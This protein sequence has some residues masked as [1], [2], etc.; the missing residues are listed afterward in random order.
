MSV[1]LRKR[2]LPSGRVQLFLDSC[3][4]HQRKREYLNLYL[5]EDRFQNKET[6][7]LAEAIRAKK[8]LDMQAQLYG[9]SAT[10][11]RKESFV[12]YANKINGRTI[13]ES[14][15]K[16]YENSLTHLKV[17]A[18]NE[19]LFGQLTIDFFEGF[20]HYLLQKV[21]Q[22]TSQMYLARIKSITS[23]AVRE[24]IIPTNPGLYVTIKKKEYI[25]IFLTLKEVRQLANTKCG[26]EDVK[27]AFLFACFSGLRYSD[28][29]A[30]SWD[31]IKD[32]Y[33]EFTQQKTGSPERMPLSTQALEILDEQS[34][35]EI[36]PKIQVAQPK[37]GVF[38][39]PRRSVVDK[40]LR[41]WAKKA[42]LTKALSF[43]K[44]RHTFATMALEFGIDIYTLSKL[45]GHRSLN[46][47]QI[48]AHVVDEKRKEA[49]SKLPKLEVLKLSLDKKVA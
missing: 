3:Q 6:M 42:E 48:Y 19:I 46:T 39:M 21:S 47:T 10:Y 43:H 22:N 32:G 2:T 41:H 14:T 5:D 34:K 26:N 20:R 37:N 7:N 31:K 8:E 18:G 35:R 38:C 9:L 33:L 49:V 45:L 13:K 4:L 24:G 1:K 25:P 16:S 11:T 17:Y 15:R 27:A 23:H 30:L 28:V 44:S 40:V 36:N 29:V 12:K